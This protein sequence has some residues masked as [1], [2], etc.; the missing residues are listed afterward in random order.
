[1]RSDAR[2]GLTEVCRYAIQD[3]PPGSALLALN[4]RLRGVSGETLGHALEVEKTLLRT[5][6]MRGAPF[7]V[8]TADAAVFTTGVLPPTEESLRRFLPGLVPSVDT[9]GITITEAVDLAA[10]EITGVLAG[11]A[12]DI[13]GLG[14]ELA[15]RIGR[16][17]TPARRAS[18]DAEGPHAP[19]QSVGE[20]VVH[21]CVRILALRGIVC[22][23]AREGR[24]YPFVL[25]AEWLGGSFPAM[26]AESARAE[27]LRRFLQWYGPATRADFAAWIGLRGGDTDPW[28][29]GLAGEITRIDHRGDSWMLTAD[30]TSGPA[31]DDGATGGAAVERVPAARG[32]RL[33]PPRDPYTQ[34]RDR[35]RILAPEYHREVWKP[36]GEPGTVLVDGRIAGIWR[37]RTRGRRLTLTVTFFNP[38][39]PRQVEDV[40]AEAER[41][42]PLR[43]AASVD[44]VV[45]TPGE[46]AAVP[47]TTP[48]RTTR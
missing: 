34:T 38:P 46:P 8:P 39:A 6:S 30:L 25:V 22:F 18:W 16:R 20:A 24:A 27:L 5:W 15:P 13:E 14:V 3:S 48:G 33:L 42:G 36:V 4:A 45:V 11:R 26:P 41:I 44:V 23:G 9:L 17:L 28:W 2:R 32:V 19:G 29:D 10:S 43:G 31:G 40:R 35:D 1:M 7:I 37:P 21:F 12:L 47:G